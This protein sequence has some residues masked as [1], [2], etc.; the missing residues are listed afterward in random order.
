[1]AVLQNEGKQTG[2]LNPSS[3][4]PIGVKREG[5]QRERTPV[6]V[7][8]AG[9]VGLA[10]TGD[11]GWRGVSC[12]LIEKTD[13]A[14]IAPKM[15][16]VGVR[17]MEFC[18]RWGIADWVRNSPY[19]RDY[20]QDNVYVTSL[21]GYE[22]GRQ[23]VLSK[24]QDPG[25]P[26]SP[27]NRERCPQDMFD[28]IL[29]RFVGTFPHVDI[30]YNT[31]LIGLEEQ[32]DG[33]VATLKHGE[34]GETYEVIADYVVG[35]DG[36]ASTVRKLLNIGMGGTPILTYST[37]VIFRCHDLPSLH[38]KGKA[39]RF[40]FIGPE[41]TWLTIVA[42]DGADRWRLSVVGTADSKTLSED[43]VRALI[44]R[45]MGRDFDYEILS[46]IPWVRRELV[47]DSYVT[48]RIFLAGDAA[49]LMS[50]TGGF[51]MNT[52]LGDSVDLG[53]KLQAVLAGWG[54]SHLLR[55]YEDERRPV[56]IRNVS[57]SSDNLRR[58]LSSRDHKPSDLVFE[59][60]EAGVQARRAFGSWY[61]ELM[62]R[63][64]FTLGIH[65]GY[66]YEQSP[67]IW[68]DGTPEPSDEVSTYTPTARPGSRAP[69]VW[70]DDGRSILDLFGRGFVLLRLSRDSTLGESLAAA[71]LER[72]VPLTI[73]E[74]NSQVVFELYESPLVLVR[75]DGHVAWRGAEDPADPGALMDVVRG[76]SRY[77]QMEADRQGI[78]KV[79][80]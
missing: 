29:R 68:P 18:R 26:E 74:L 59:D 32:S 4:T 53:W 25:P 46:I 10:L 23:V 7:I 8:G 52:G 39:Y 21:L 16:M 40:I 24:D 30:H 35:T 28:P 48:N 67:V 9:P 61:A 17:S 79:K 15:D 62:R 27:E 49:H 47:A 75:P 60:S 22:L 36:G 3:D 56:A 51:G 43:D 19:P 70:L 45:A 11:L 58:M 31:E 37:N 44:R 42:I 71:A 69:H 73:V 13:G 20:P 5:K 66:H 57:E 1:M 54:G 64:W 12:T 2:D 76:V 63:E 50:P 80:L 55:S 78:H 77:P 34:S 41:G 14:I 38:D 33:V 6:L 65:L 72:N